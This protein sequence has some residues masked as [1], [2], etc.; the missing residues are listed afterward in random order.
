MADSLRSARLR[1]SRKRSNLIRQALM[2]QAWRGRWPDV[3]AARPA[4]ANSPSA[5]RLL[6]AGLLSLDTR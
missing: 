5:H 6:R 3:R 4:P 2:L 1:G